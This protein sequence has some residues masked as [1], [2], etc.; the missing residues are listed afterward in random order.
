MRFTVRAAWV[1]RERS[2][3]ILQIV[4]CTIV[5]GLYNLALL[6]LYTSFS[7]F[8]FHIEC[9]IRCY[10]CSYHRRRRRRHCFCCLVSLL[11]LLLLLLL[12]LPY[13]S[14]QHHF[15]YFSD[16]CSKSWQM[17]FLLPD[18]LQTIFWVFLLAVQY[19]YKECVCVFAVAWYLSIE[20]TKRGWMLN[21]ESRQIDR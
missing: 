20:Q 16:K 5:S 9:T 3:N 12:L 1:R 4:L 7:R 11:I 18:P 17:L 10:C 6:L 13:R 15:H 21:T 14:R 19:L 8:A 2:L